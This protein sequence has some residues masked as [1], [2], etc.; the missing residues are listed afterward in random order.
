MLIAI[1]TQ[2][3]HTMCTGGRSLSMVA[4]M[5]AI[6]EGSDSLSGMLD[7]MADLYEAETDDL[8]DGLRSPCNCSSWRH[9]SVAVDSSMTAMYLPFFK[10]RLLI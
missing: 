5:V 9:W 8:V 7:E 10:L 6:N 2:L 3:Q 1:G 4:Q